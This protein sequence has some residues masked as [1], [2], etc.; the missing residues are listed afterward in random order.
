SNKAMLAGIDAEVSNPPQISSVQH[1]TWAKGAGVQG[2]DVAI[3]R[4]DGKSWQTISTNTPGT[5]MAWIVT[6][7]GTPHARAR[8]TD[9]VIA[10]RRDRAAGTSCVP[11]G[12]SS[13]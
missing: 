6:P 7:P 4:D 11:A 12:Q 1:I 9:A 3:S 13:R 8:V 10:W 5:D 2:V